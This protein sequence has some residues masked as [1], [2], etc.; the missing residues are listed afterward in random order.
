M[1]VSAL[2]V[3]P[4]LTGGLLTPRRS[5]TVA[6]KSSVNRCA[7]A[8]AHYRNPQQMIAEP[9]AL[10]DER[11]NALLVATAKQLSHELKLAVPR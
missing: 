8:Q 1:S 7:V 4:L 9:F 2:S 11:M 5:L 10:N 3:Q 6:N